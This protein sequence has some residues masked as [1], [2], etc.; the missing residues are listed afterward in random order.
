MRHFASFLLLGLSL[1]AGGPSTLKGTPETDWNGAL[2]VY[3]RR[4]HPPEQS[5]AV[6]WQGRIS[7]L[8]KEEPGDLV[9]T[10]VGDL[11]LNAPISGHRDPAHRQ[12]Y[13]LLQEADL[14]YGNLECSLNDHPEELGT[15]YNF[16]ADRKLGWE[17]AALGFNL[18]GMANNHTFDF[19]GKGLQDCLDTLEQC[20]ITHAGAGMTLEAAEEPG[21]Q[22]VQGQKQKVA[23]LSLMRFW[24]Q[25]FRSRNA[26]GPSVATLN[27]ATILVAS[28]S[29]VEAVEGVQEEDILAMED[30]IL[31]A[32]RRG[33][34]VVVAL[35]NH[36]VSHNRAFGIQEVTPANDEIMF[37]RAIEAGAD[38]V[39]G[40]GPHVLR[41]LEL[42]QGRPIL[43]SLGNFI[44]QYRTPERIPVDLTHQ[45]DPEMP[46][47]ANVSVWDRRDSPE[48]MEAVVAR[49]VLN[50]GKL[51]RL[52]LIPVAIA[53]EGP[54]F[55]V[56]SL[57]SD[58][59]ARVILDRMKRLSEPLGTRFEDHGWYLETRLP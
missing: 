36:D 20:R 35:H 59:R 17:L 16:R 38:M 43:Y 7:S 58:A 47:Q 4:I 28:G 33:H 55:G 54:D 15:F 34:L 37:R 51:R 3:A 46:R 30:R 21:I 22:S 39:L 41:G 42:H 56:P 11:I 52:Q 12:L 9:V 2:S 24:S 44:Y 57:V 10:A 14:C 5:P 23:L 8:L 18:L 31:Q 40:S 29:R 13:R 50:Q 27:P 48:V 6:D 1:V 45:R 25:R 53:D 26:A 32:K 19:G 49:L